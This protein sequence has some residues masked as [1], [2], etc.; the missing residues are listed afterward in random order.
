MAT[1][2]ALFT[3]V[4]A[5]TSG[6]SSKAAA[7]AAA[8]LISSGAD[9]FLACVAHVLSGPAKAPFGRFFPFIAECCALQQGAL[10]VPV[11]EV[12]PLAR[13][14]ATAEAAFLAV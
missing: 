12:R 14:D 3:E 4:Q 7:K 2:A 1:F 6:F 10:L 9:S 8:R 11:L 5:A 13:G